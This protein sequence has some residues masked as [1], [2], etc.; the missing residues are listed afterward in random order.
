[1]KSSPP[2][3]LDLH[4]G[5]VVEQRAVAGI[6]LVVVVVGAPDR[7]VQLA[8]VRVPAAAVHVLAVDLLSAPV[9]VVAVLL[10]RNGCNQSL[11]RSNA[12][13]INGRPFLLPIS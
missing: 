12:L 7:Q 6:P 13:K 2:V 9:M 1:M 10:L 4:G 11:S 5:G 8:A 3:R